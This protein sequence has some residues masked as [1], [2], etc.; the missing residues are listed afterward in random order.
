MEQFRYNHW[1][2]FHLYVAFFCPNI[3]LGKAKTGSDDLELACKGTCNAHFEVIS[4][5]NPQIYRLQK[6]IAERAL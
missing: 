4:V 6:P 2:H 1:F 5:E 3:H